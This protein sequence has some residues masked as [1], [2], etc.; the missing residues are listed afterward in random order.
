MG[1]PSPRRASEDGLKPGTTDMFSCA[2]VNL[3]YGESPSAAGLTNL[4]ALLLWCTSCSAEAAG[5]G[6][7]PKGSPG[8]T[9]HHSRQPLQQCRGFFIGQNL[10]CCR[11][12]G[13]CLL[14]VTPKT[15]FYPPP[16]SP[17]TYRIDTGYM[18]LIMTFRV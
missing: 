16:S 8:G 11:A 6:G 13:A 1:L 10:L 9:R 2:T 7:L 18:D 5:H 14:T 17:V 12:R 15:L 3:D 4:M